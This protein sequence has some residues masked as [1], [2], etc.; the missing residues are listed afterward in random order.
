MTS[1]LNIPGNAFDTIVPQSMVSHGTR[2]IITD[3]RIVIVDD[4]P[5]NIKVVRRL[6][7][8]EGYGQIVT[9][10]DAR[11]AIG[12]IQ[13]ETPDLVLLDLMMPHVSGLEILSAIRQ[14]H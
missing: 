13:Q 6:L 14:G 3:A 5:V 9:T 8:I 11:E 12:L 4:E 7:K 1:L 10:C 2:P